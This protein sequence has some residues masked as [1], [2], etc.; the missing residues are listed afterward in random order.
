MKYMLLIY[1][2]AELWSSF[3]QEDMERLV[4]ETDALQP[5]AHHL[6]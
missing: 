5:G 1:G 4:Q 3:P 2:N 6:G